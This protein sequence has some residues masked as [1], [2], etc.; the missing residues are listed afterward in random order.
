MFGEEDGDGPQDAVCLRHYDGPGANGI[1]ASLF[2]ERHGVRL[3]G[4][5]EHRVQAQTHFLRRQYDECALRQH[6]EL[7]ARAPA[8]HPDHRLVAVHADMRSVR[9][10]ARVVAE[11]ERVRERIH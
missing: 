5:K 3:A 6:H 7:L 11:R 10:D 4:R 1:R 8:Q 9:G 2:S